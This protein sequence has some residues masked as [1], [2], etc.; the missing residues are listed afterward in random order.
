MIYIFLEIHSG[1]HV[2]MDH[3]QMRKW[4]VAKCGSREVTEVS[5]GREDGGLHYG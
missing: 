2:E 1:S 5:Q 3:G 4:E